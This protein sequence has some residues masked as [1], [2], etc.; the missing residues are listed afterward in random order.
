MNLYRT[1]TLLHN[2]SLEHEIVCHLSYTYAFLWRG[3][4]SLHQILTQRFLTHNKVK[5]QWSKPTYRFCMWGNWGLNKR[6]SQ[7]RNLWPEILFL[8]LTED[9]LRWAVTSATSSSPCLAMRATTLFTDLNISSC[10][11]GAVGLSTTSPPPGTGSFSLRT[12]PRKDL[13]G[14]VSVQECKSQ[15]GD[16]LR[17]LTLNPGVFLN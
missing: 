10:P 1:F 7:D 15:P 12:R 13:A 6:L 17:I 11:W 8:P 5:N 16:R 9:W 3:S 4:L 2:K 14:W